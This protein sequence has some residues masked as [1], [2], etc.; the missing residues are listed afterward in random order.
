MKILY[1]HESLLWCA[2][3][4]GGVMGRYYVTISLKRLTKDM[5]GVAKSGNL[6]DTF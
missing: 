6:S 2:F 5:C 4:P 3:W 1:T